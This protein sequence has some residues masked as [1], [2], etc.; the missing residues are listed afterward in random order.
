MQTAYE[1]NV[2]FPQDKG[3]GLSVENRNYKSSTRARKA[4]TWRIGASL[5]GAGGRN[6]NQNKPPI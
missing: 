6:R 4:E 3:N 2:D 5:P 1:T